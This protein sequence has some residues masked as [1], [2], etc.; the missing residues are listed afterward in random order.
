MEA[1]EEALAAEALIVVMV[2]REGALEE[3]IADWVATEEVE[4]AEAVLVEVAQEN[5]HIQL[6]LRQILFWTPMEYVTY[7]RII[8][9]PT[10]FQNMGHNKLL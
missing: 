3:V 7:L 2:A 5:H 8:T 1:K 10:H 9:L 4:E 6:A